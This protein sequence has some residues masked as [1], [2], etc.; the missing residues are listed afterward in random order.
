MLA[1]QHLSDVNVARLEQFYEDARQRIKAVT[2][3][4][5]LW[6]K[7]MTILAGGGVIALFTLLG[8]VEALTV[9]PIG[10]WFAFAG[11]I[12]SLVSVMA[13]LFCGYLG[14]DCFYEA[15]FRT[16]EN[17][18]QEITGGET[19]QETPGWSEGK[20]WHIAA[21]LLAMLSLILFSIG[22]ACALMAVRPD[23]WSST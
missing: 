16:A 7:S 21:L 22:S 6:L 23:L 5:V 3:L 1:P 11:L 19:R 10:L 14:Q 12:G 8:K 15:E 18:Y 13:A 17:I 20:R 9:N 4:A 2:D